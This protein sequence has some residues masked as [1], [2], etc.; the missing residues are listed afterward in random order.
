LCWKRVGNYQKATSGQLTPRVSSSTSLLIQGLETQL[1]I[2]LRGRFGSEFEGTQKA[3][4][5]ETEISYPPGQ[6]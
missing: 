3:L 4:Q 6:K 5:K 2:F 1:F